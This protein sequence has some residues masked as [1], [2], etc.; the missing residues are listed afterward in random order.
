MRQPD[1]SLF[2]EE[3]HNSKE[4]S[5]IDRHLRVMLQPFE[6]QLNPT[7]IQSLFAP[8]ETEENILF[9]GWNILDLNWII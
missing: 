7:C 1:Y 3:I 2:Y 5:F 4:I 8:G 9:A 6:A